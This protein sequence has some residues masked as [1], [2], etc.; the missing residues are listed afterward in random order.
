MLEDCLNIKHL[1]IK[2]LQKIIEEMYW[3][4]QLKCSL[5]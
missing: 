4:N 5:A 2:Q 1:M 3:P